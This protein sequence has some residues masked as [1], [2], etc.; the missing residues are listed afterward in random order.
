MPL[1]TSEDNQA[2]S[3]GA[4]RLEGVT[5]EDQDSQNFDEGEE[6]TPTEA[7]L[8]EIREQVEAPRTEGEED[9]LVRDT[10]S[11]CT[12]RSMYDFCLFVF[13][14]HKQTLN[15]LLVNSV[16]GVCDTTI[17]HFV[18]YLHTAIYQGNNMAFQSY[19][20]RKWFSCAP[21]PCRSTHTC[22]GFAI[23]GTEWRSCWGEVFRFYR[24][25]GSGAVR[26]GDVVG[27]YYPR[28][29][30]KWLG[31]SGGNCVK[32]TC[33]GTPS[34]TYG[35]QNSEKWTV[36]VGEVFVIYAQGKRV[37]SVINERDIIMLHY[38]IGN[39]W[40]NLANTIVARGSGPGR[41]RPPSAATYERNWS[42]TLEV[43]KQ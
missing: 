21:N 16:H 12:Y 9:L 35:F 2:I 38:L 29:P 37:G 18:L 36:C 28:E 40:V 14:K 7:Y 32:A 43:W 10:R 3:E 39:Q 26:V 5:T 8:E 20:R 1:S 31:C 11:T 24:A 34:T 30:G 13:C 23:S 41:T 17:L 22:A 15:L 25:R 42:Y 33:P 19:H 27:V 6:P 4:D